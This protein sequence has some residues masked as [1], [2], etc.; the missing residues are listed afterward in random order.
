MSGVIESFLLF[1]IVLGGLFAGWFT[2]T[3]AAAVGCLGALVVCTIQGK[4]KWESF[5]SSMKNT[6]I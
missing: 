4:L 6:Q 3:E 1:A 5:Q 2:S